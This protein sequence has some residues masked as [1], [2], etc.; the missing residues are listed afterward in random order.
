MNGPFKVEFVRVIEPLSKLT[1]ML[2]RSDPVAGLVGRTA[3]EAA[4]TGQVG[5]ALLAFGI[6]ASGNELPIPGGRDGPLGT[7]V[8]VIQGIGGAQTVGLSTAITYSIYGAGATITS[9]GV[10]AVGPAALAGM[11]GYEIG[12]AGYNLWE[13]MWGVRLGVQIY[14]LFYAEPQF[15][16]TTLECN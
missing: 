8:D 4:V 14:E 9:A 5:D 13:R 6:T 1:S 11:G 15:E 10:A 12:T 3:E 7:V 2:L 16:V